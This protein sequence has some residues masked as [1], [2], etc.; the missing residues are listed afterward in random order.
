[1]QRFSPLVPR[2][3]QTTFPFG[4]ASFHPPL[5]LI[6]SYKTGGFASTATKTTAPSSIE[7]IL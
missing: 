2:L 5:Q 6:P 4:G 1:M 3:R 7:D